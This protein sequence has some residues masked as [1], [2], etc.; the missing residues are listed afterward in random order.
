MPDLT[1][2]LLFYLPL[3]IV[4]AWRWG[5]WV[6]KRTVGIFYRPVA[7]SYRTTVSVVTPVI[8]EDPRLFREVLQSWKVNRPSE[9][10][11]VID[12]TDKDCI[13]IFEE[14]SRDFDGARL[15]VTEKLGKRPALA[16]GIRASSGEIAALVDSDVV[17]SPSL[18]DE[19]LRPFADPA[20]GGVT[21]RQN[22]LDPTTLAQRIFDIQLDLRY[23]DDVMPSAAAGD[24]FTCLS[25][26]TALYRRAAIMPVL[27]DMVN[28]T[29]WG[30]QCIGG[31]DKRLTYL[32]EAAGW[33]ARY[34]H[35]ARVYTSGAPKMTTLVKQRTRWGRNSWRADLRAM[36]QG[37]VWKHPFFAFILLDRTISNF[38]LLVSLAYMV[39]SLALQL[40]TPAA[41]LLA[42]WLFTRTLRLIPNLARHPA[43]VLIVPV[44]IGTNFAMAI[45]RI[46]ALLSLNRQDWLT[47]AALHQPGN[48]GLVLA[49]VGT[50]LIVAGLCAAVYFYRFTRG[51]SGLIPVN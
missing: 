9:I 1:S 29:F 41:A 49:R 42:W 44:Y 28:E 51:V 19:A 50:L 38:T 48:P 26:R 15:I 31:E 10:I 4:G 43:N 25:G 21:T 37:W 17:W 7:G 46:Y 6:L 14:F 8:R 5:A 12:H 20:V 36:W 23:F 45:V 33:K 35:D 34:Q 3:G 2:L 13:R 32:V 47:R 22:V 27:D 16:D 11:A 18:L 30:R 24:V 39:V 40:W